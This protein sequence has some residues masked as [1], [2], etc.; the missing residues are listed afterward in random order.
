MSAFSAHKET[1]CGFFAD[2]P[3][4][5]LVPSSDKSRR[6]LEPFRDLRGNGFSVEWPLPDYGLI[7]AFACPWMW[8][9]RGQ[10]EDLD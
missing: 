1:L 8:T 9:A 10:A 4:L 3:G 2:Y 5:F 6:W 7:K